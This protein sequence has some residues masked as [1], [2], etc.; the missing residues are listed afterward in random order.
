MWTAIRRDPEK[1]RADTCAEKDKEDI[2]QLV[3]W[4][5][6][7]GNE[8]F[9]PNGWLYD[10][11]TNKPLQNKNEIKN[12]NTYTVPNV[13]L[14][15]K[16]WALLIRGQYLSVYR[17][18]MWEL[19]DFRK[20]IAGEAIFNYAGKYGIGTGYKV[21]YIGGKGKFGAKL[22]DIQNGLNDRN[23]AIW[24]HFGHGVG[25]KLALLSANEKP[26]SQGWRY[27]L[28]GSSNFKRPKGQHKLAI[29][30]FYSCDVGRASWW[31]LLSPNGK[32]YAKKTSVSPSKEEYP[33][34]PIVP[35]PKK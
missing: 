14:V 19:S 2:D 24:A 4:T 13:A 32:L 10:K 34:I 28:Y 31:H 29:V 9:G 18:T 6:L 5:L 23:L 8:A 12:G 17:N 3:E 25:K 16:G 33:D 30:L 11:E 27:R 35:R 20:D 21:K 26:D 7:D 15:S 22:V 1:E